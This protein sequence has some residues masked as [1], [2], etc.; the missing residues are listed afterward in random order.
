MAIRFTLSLLFLGLFI[1]LSSAQQAIFAGK[2]ITGITSAEFE[3]E[4]TNWRVFELD[5]AALQAFAGSQPVSANLRLQLGDAYD[6]PISLH[7]DDIRSADYQLRVLTENGLQILPK[8]ENITYGG[9]AAGQPEN[10]VRMTLSQNFIFGYVEMGE[11][12]FFIEPAKRFK[13]DLPETYYVVYRT[14]D[15][16]PH[17]E[18]RC[19]WTETEHRKAALEHSEHGEEKMF[20]NCYTVEIALASDFSM[21]QVFGSVFGVQDFMLGVLNNVQT[22][23][24]TEFADEIRFEVVTQ[25]VVATSG[26]NPW[27]SSTDAE[28]LLISF[29]NWGNAGNFGVPFDVATLWTNRNFDGSTIGVAWLGGLCSEL[30][31]NTCQLFS[32]NAAFLRVLQAHELGHNFGA[33]HDAEGSNTIMAP[34]VNS[35]T[36]WSSLSISDINS[37]VNDLAFGGGCFSTCTGSGG[38]PIASISAPTVHVCAGSVVPLI[39]NSANA[40]TSWTWNMPGATPSISGEQHPTVKYNNPGNYTA[41]LI[42]TNNEGTDVANVN[43][44]VDDGGTKYLIYETFEANPGFWEIINPDNGITWEWVTIGGAQYGKKAM[45]LNNFNYT[46]LNQKDALVSV[47]LDL[48]SESEVML[49]IDY[50]YRRFNASRSDKLIVSVSTNGGLTYPNVVFQGQETGGGN[51]ATATDSQTSFLPATN[52]DWCFGTNFGSG[53]LLI[54]LSA[55]SGQSQVR[56]RIENQ[57]GH[58]NNMY[59]DNIRVSSSCAA[60][61]PPAPNFTSNITSGCAPLTVQYTNQTPGVVTNYFW[62]FPGG[63]PE[64]STNTNPVVTYNT[65]GVYNVS[66]EATNLGGPATIIKAGYITVSGGPTANFSTVVNNLNVQTTNLSANATNYVWN[67]GDGTPNST[68]TSPAHVYAQPGTYTIRLTATNPCGQSVKEI[69]VTVTAPITA[70]FSATPLQ[71][72]A[73]LTVTFNNESTG[74]VTGWMWTFEGGTPATSTDQNPTVT[75]QE[76]GAYPVSLTVSNGSF[77]N[78]T[79]LID[80]VI[81]SG[82]PATAFTTLNPI[83]NPSVQFT[84]ATTG[85]TSYL[86]DFGDGAT[87]E[88][89][90][91][92]HTYEAD[93]TYTVT[94][95]ATN[96]CGSDTATQEI[97]IL[98]P[99]TASWE[100]NGNEGCE[101]LSVQF[102]AAPQGPGLAYAWTFEGGE[103]A[104]SDLPDPTVSYP[105]SGTYS[106]QLIVT[107]A[108]GSD[109]II[110]DDGIVV[111]PNPLAAFAA[112]AILG[113]ASVQFDNASIAASSYSWDF[114]DGAMSEAANPSHNYEADGMYTVTLIATNTCGSDTATQE[115]TILLPPVANWEQN[116]NQGCEGLSIQFNAAPQ[117]PGLTYSWTFEGGEPASSDLADPTVSYQISGI[118]SV[119]LIVSNAAGSDTI[120]QDEAIVVG[121]NPLAAFAA[122]AILGQASVQ[123]DNTSIAASSFHWDFGDGSTSDDANPAHNY[124]AD[125]TYT[126]ILIATN[127][128]SS[129]TATQE[130]SILLP[131]TASWE[132]NLGEGC[133]GLSIQ[134]NAAPQGPGLTYSWTFEGGEPASSNLPD[135]TVSYPISGT[136]SVQLIVTNAAG[137]DTIIQDDGIVVG[138]N[139]LAAFAANSALGQA[140]VQFDNASIAASSYS[141]DFGDGA[142]SEAT[143]PAHNYEADGTYTV[144]LIATNAC[145][146]DTANQEVVILLPPSASWEQNLGE[147]CE[148]LTVQFNAAPQGPG[149]T[150]SWTFEGG[151]PASS[152]LPSPT[153][154]Y[155][156]A[157]TFPVQLIVTNAAGADTT[158]Q[159]EA[160]VVG[161][162]P[163]AAFTANS[164]LGQAS[165]QFNNASIAA[166]SFHWDF[167]D[168]ATSDDANPAHNYE[169]DGTY[170]VILIATNACGSD[171]AIQEVTILLPPNATWE[172]NTNQGCEGLTVQFNAGPQGPGLTYSWTFEGG[173]PASSNLP[174]P[175][176]SYPI[177]GTY[178]VQLI[179]TNAAGADTLDQS[180]AVVITGGPTALFMPSVN[181]F[182]LALEN[183]SSGASS[184]FW[185]FGDENTSDLFAPGHIYEEE[186]VYTIILVVSN[187]CGSDTSAT[188]ITIDS[189]LPM[190]GFSFENQEGCAPLTVQFFNESVNADSVQWSF[191]GGTPS[192]SSEQN[193]VV[194]YAEPGI[195][196]ATIVSYNSAGSAAQIQMNIVSV[197]AG[198][199]AA[200]DATQDEATVS[201]VN[202]SQNAATYEWHFGDGE[203]STASNPVHTYTATGDYPVQL[204]ATSECGSDTITKVVNIL[205]VSAG[206][207]TRNV[208]FNLYPNPNN[209]R[210]TL[211]LEATPAPLAELKI[212]D[213]LGQIVYTETVGFQSGQLQKTMLLE[214]LSAGVYWL[215]IKTQDFNITRKV[216]VQ[217]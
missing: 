152:N 84:N 140:S 50:A 119:Q 133:E 46:A 122:N 135:P 5:A 111:G 185:D 197:M 175:T 120:I 30:R 169:A 3:R 171:T 34:S 104:S 60:P 107:N 2:E 114:G 157:G 149:L 67:F 59:I 186:G 205:I 88:A 150:Y 36:A 174:D 15:V 156:A 108:A 212:F 148:G 211:D 40:P 194:V 125:G 57:T 87:S 38:P 22:N 154:L 188:A 162:N 138:P 215:S 94:L 206:E 201:F 55:F 102:N 26:G 13:A 69:S 165:V 43:I 68:A 63:T 72:C 113:Q 79:Q 105:I 209:G 70:A 203:T 73:P 80:Y 172:Q 52:S 214:R 183:N 8:G 190:A 207:T 33:D 116:A 96:T 32:S 178:S 192:A 110:Q 17:P 98:L 115:I 168:G 77:Q 187:E 180:N 9:Y 216:I 29:R 41:T 182:N 176:V 81:V 160:I 151:E 177:S 145:G 90:D 184:Y 101:G 37:L 210:F 134:F 27:S 95:I 217:Y 99:P 24:D 58:G 198:P 143:N 106:V 39:D 170:T 78:S 53:C 12:T 139:P 179:V 100:Q 25:F 61:Q 48:S 62:T 164:A 75:Y 19:G 103:P 42:A 181:G 199:E 18:S 16:R 173:V 158:I 86:W 167:G 97:T 64:F 28:I 112:N 146:S 74:N 76:P 147:G 161:P 92:S 93:G 4:F 85:A 10:D 11:L 155:A 66:L 163:L 83:G 123:F 128:C 141:W 54:D 82:L 49:E 127:A 189:N 14:D 213:A 118:Y 124:E 196:N 208:F 45:S 130:V 7:P 153:V 35:S 136:Y 117:G 47:P 23:Y 142:T 166:S 137:A 89:A 191:P 193:P 56:I 51:F 31:Y 65:P 159:D 121:P 195:Y 1:Q 202:S 71:G 131:P 21:F 91:T 132:Q 109:T 129:D 126:V 6:W 200:F 20:G 44:Q 204:I 144:I